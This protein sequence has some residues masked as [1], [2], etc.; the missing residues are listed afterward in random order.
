MSQQP[1]EVTT[2]AFHWVFQRPDGAGFAT[3]SHDRPLRVG[4]TIFEADM[5][6]H[7]A[8]L[9]LSERM[10][11]SSLRVKGALSN[12]ALNSTDILSG[13]WSGTSVTLVTADWSNGSEASIICKGE[14]GHLKFDDGVLSMIVDVLPDASRDSPCPQTSPECRAVLGDERCRVDL[15]SRKMRVTVAAV[16][17]S[18]VVIDETYTEGFV[19]GQ[20][21]WLTGKCSGMKQ[22]IVAA[23]GARLMLQARLHDKVESGDRALLVEGCDGRRATC[24]ER[25]GNILN[26]RGEPDLP[27]S[28][29]LLR[30]PGA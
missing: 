29:I 24:A 16:E 23:D 26:F 10:L 12:P 30:F 8:E 19:M 13:R 2:Q 3:T 22:T 21:R 7:P 28:E 11:G 5:D 20:L 15:R 1:D 18:I 27:G 17:D 4:S 25:F 6:L 9:V 14:L